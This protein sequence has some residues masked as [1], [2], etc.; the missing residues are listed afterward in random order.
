LDWDSGQI[1]SRH[2]FIAT[3]LAC[4]RVGVP[5]LSGAGAGGVGRRGRDGDM[6]C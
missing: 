3:Q 4:V 5:L 1:H 2:I 6:A